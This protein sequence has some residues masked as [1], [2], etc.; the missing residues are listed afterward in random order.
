MD[1][2]IHATHLAEFRQRVYQTFNNRADTLME[3]LDTL[4]SNRDAQ[5][6][7]ELSLNPVFRRSYS[8][9]FKGIAAGHLTE[10]GMGRLIKPHLASPQERRY[11]LF[12]VDVTPQR[13]QFAPCVADRSYVYYPNAIKGNKPVTVGHQ[14]A[15]VGYLPEKTVETG[16]WIVPLLTSRVGSDE[17]KEMVGARQMGQLLGDESHPFHG[18]LCVEAADAAY[19]KPAYL[20]A[21][22]HHP[23][24]VKIVRVRSNRV[25]YQSYQ[26][27]DDAEKGRGHPTWYGYRFALKEPDTWHEPGE[28]VQTRYRSHRGKIYQVVIQA[29][30]NMLMR[31]KRKPKRIPMLGTPAKP[32]QPRNNSG[33]RLPG[34][35][36]PPRKRY[37]VVKKG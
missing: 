3:L 4:S 15:T 21:N 26:A 28:T 2:E 9:L 29:W 32:P 19:S 12:G 31:G 5:T 30:H 6:V 33:G 1:R 13:R 14:Y 24:L 16:S 7:V 17:D 25:F 8:T 36:L 11:W 35:K 10:E 34:T 23:N 27:A 20:H 37:K 18:Q 22:L